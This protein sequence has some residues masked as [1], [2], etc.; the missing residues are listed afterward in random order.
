MSLTI[1]AKAELPVF[2]DQLEQILSTLPQVSWCQR[3]THYD[4]ILNLTVSG[5]QLE[6]HRDKQKTVVRV[7]FVEGY[8]AH[9]RQYG[10]GRQQPMARAVL[11]NRHKEQHI[12]DATA[13]LGRDGFVMAHLGARVTMIERH[14]LIFALLK[15]GLDRAKLNTETAETAERISLHQADSLRYCQQLQQA[16]TKDHPAIIYM[17]PMYP[18]RKKSALVKKDMRLLKDLLSMPGL[19]SNSVS[20]PQAASHALTEAWFEQLMA[21]C[22]QRMVVKRPKGAAALVASPKPN[23]EITS[24]NTRYDIYLT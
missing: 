16:E 11:L 10:G 8:H 22:T 5:L 13:G 15:D 14:P 12:L 2:L 6:D 18:E 20:D 4:L 7:D 23:T 1:G 3:Q 24:K 9:R 19:D 17:D 21:C